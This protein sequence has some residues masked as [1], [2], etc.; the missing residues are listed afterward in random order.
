[1]IKTSNKT[2][3]IKKGKSD[4]TIIYFMIYASYEKMNKY[5]NK[6]MQDHGAN[7]ALK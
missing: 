6:D 5:Y 3:K 1:M 7:S 2:P 4:S